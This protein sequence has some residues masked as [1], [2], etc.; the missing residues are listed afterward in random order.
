MFRA[1]QSWDGEIPGVHLLGEPIHFPA[2]VNEDHS[3]SDGQSL[4]EITQRVQLPFLTHTQKHHPLDFSM[5]LHQNAY[6]CPHT[7]FT[8]HQTASYYKLSALYLF[9]N[10][11][12]ELTN[13]L[14]GELLFLHQDTHWLTHKL[15]GD[16]Q[17]LCRHGGWQQHHLKA[18]TQNDTLRPFHM[19]GILINKIID[20]CLLNGTYCYNNIPVLTVKNNLYVYDFCFL[21]CM[22][23]VSFWKIS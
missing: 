21:T 17:H 22:L 11:D 6:I 13:T 12:V 3:L 5:I 16:I 1:Y 8:Q 4:I 9:L 14:K 20:Y 19:I 10:V 23:E 2:R 7:E 18:R 15:G